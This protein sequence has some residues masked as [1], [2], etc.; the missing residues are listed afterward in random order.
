MD[1]LYA[2]KNKWKYILLMIFFN[3]IVSYFITDSSYYIDK[4]NIGERVPVGFITKD[5]TVAQEFIP[6]S[7]HMTGIEVEFATY[8][9]KNDSNVFV[10]L[11]DMEK[12]SVIFEKKIYAKNMADNHYRMFKFR[13]IPDSKN[14]KYLITVESDATTDNAVTIWK[15]NTEY[16][17]V[18]LSIGKEKV[19]GSLNFRIHFVLTDSLNTAPLLLTIFFN[20]LC[21]ILIGENRISGYIFLKSDELGVKSA[22]TTENI[23]RYRF[24]IIFA[25]FA[26]FV[27]CK[28][29]FSSIGMW[30]DLLRDKIDYSQKTKIIGKIRGIRSDEWLVQTPLYIAQ[31]NNE[32]FFPVR[33]HNILS[34]GLNTIISAGA[35][36]FDWTLI[37]KPFNWG[38][39]LFGSERGLSWYWCSRLF[40]LLILS[41]EVSMLLT[42]GKMLYSIAG[43]FLITF[44]S[45]VQW[46]FSTSLVDMLIFSQGMIILIDNYFNPNAVY[47]KIIFAFLFV[48]CAN[49]FALCLYPAWVVPMGYLTLVFCAAILY[50]HWKN[51]KL[52]VKIPDALIFCVII[53]ITFLNLY[54]FYTI[55]KDDI[56]TIMNSVYPGRRF[57]TGGGYDIFNLQL[58]ILSWLLPY[59]DVSFSNNCEISTFIHFMPLV[60]VLFFKMVKA[61]KNNRILIISLF[62]FYILQLIW[63]IFPMPAAIARITLMYHVHV[64]RLQVITNLTGLYLSVW[65]IP[66]LLDKEFFKLSDKFKL[67]LIIFITVAIFA[68]I[69]NNRDITEYLTLKGIIVTLSLYLLMYLALIFKLNKIFVNTLILYIIIS[70]L[71]V[72][73]L[74]RGLSSIYNKKIS[75]HIIQINNND[76]GKTWVALDSMFHGNLLIALGCKSFNGVNYYPDFDK[77]NKLDPENKYSEIYNRYA[78]LIVK[79][80][81]VSDILFKLENP[82]VY[83][84]TMSQNQIKNKTDI[85]Y[86][87][88]SESLENY[89][90]DE[91]MFIKLYEDKQDRLNIYE[92]K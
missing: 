29:H 18:N 3:I 60:F 22:F 23:Y 34:S 8:A 14:K 90:T 64:N 51:G 77:L 19:N 78:H 17:N 81:D 85:K 1:I 61:E 21:L 71:T 37:A 32:K 54:H 58:Y 31:C 10:K 47:K 42:K 82:D 30:D 89:S 48:I 36:S 70:G 55:S 41:F 9:R 63:L 72:N 11:I 13:Q 6:E 39:I 87:V 12:G 20:L 40:L 56:H 7:D 44:S 62:I 50:N 52:T 69:F 68:G 53:L 24:L 91:V 79:I 59:K 28:L 80:A 27:M 73:P 84:I 76:P 45:A 57:L 43:A 75:N 26:V 92:V 86:I 5:V 88:S 38:F 49:G 83:S 65:A 35:P 46:W 25:I 2:L 33:N 4:Y 66:I 16:K 15:N 74:S 67:F